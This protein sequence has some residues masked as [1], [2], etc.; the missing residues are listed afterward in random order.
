LRNPQAAVR[1]VGA[2]ALSIEALIL[3]LAI[4]PL[5]RIGGPHRGFAIALVSVLAVVAV[6]FVRLLRRP[7]AWHAA[8]GIQGVLVA[9]GLLHWSLGVLGVLFGLVWLYVLSVR[10]TVLSGGPANGSA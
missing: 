3:L 2:A 8:W 9:A 4:A 10:R 6:A 7:W 5:A 1:G